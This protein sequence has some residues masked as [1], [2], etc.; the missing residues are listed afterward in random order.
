M[1]NLASLIPSWFLIALDIVD[2]ANIL[3]L[4]PHTSHSHT[5]FFF[6]INKELANRGHTITHW[7]SQITLEYALRNVNRL[8]RLLQ[9]PGILSPVKH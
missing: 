7:N 9:W 6:Y 4:S 8:Q 5:H 3:F 1:K 2:G